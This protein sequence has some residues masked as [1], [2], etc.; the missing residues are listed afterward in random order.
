MPKKRIGIVGQHNDADVQEL[1]TEI[2]DRGGEARIIDLSLFPSVVRATISDGEVVFD[3]MNL[4]DFDGFYLRRLAS[5]WNL[6]LKRFTKDEWIAYYERFNDYMDTVRAIHSFKLSMIRVLCERKFVINPYRAWGYHHLK[7]HQFCVL[8]QNGFK[9]PPFISGNNYFDL[10]TFLGQ[11]EAVQKPV[12]TGPVRMADAG[13]LE[14]SRTTLR[15]RPTVYQEFIPGASI[16]AFVLGEECIVACELPRKK[17][18]VD[19]SE[20]LEFMKRIDIPR[21][22]EKELVRAAKTF[23]MIFS[24]IDLQQDESSG[25]YYFLECNSAPYFRPYDAQVDA[26]IGGRLADFLLERS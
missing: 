7:L 13:T 18:G 21:E 22:L 1:K 16:R 12:V 6:P 25:E 26:G 17:W 23:G 11:R 19:A 5:V 8:K 3:G 9:I 2:E 4:L 10:E 20:S 24:G 14:S 15:Q